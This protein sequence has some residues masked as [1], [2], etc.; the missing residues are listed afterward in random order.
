[1]SAARPSARPPDG[2]LRVRIAVPGGSGDHRRPDSEL[3]QV[4][5]L[6]RRWHREIGA[7]P[8]ELTCQPVPGLKMRDVAGHPAQV[9][10][11]LIVFEGGL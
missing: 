7:L 2:V 9:E 6:P 4:L 11:V 10:G 5:L 3:E 1:M 8:G